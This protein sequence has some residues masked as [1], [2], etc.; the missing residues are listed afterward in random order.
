M[1]KLT[2]K[3]ILLAACLAFTARGAN[4]QTETQHY[5]SVIKDH[6]F[7][8]YKGMF[9]PAKGYLKHPFIT[10]GCSSYQDQL[11]DWD[12]WLTDVAL[13][14][15]LLE[16]GSAKDKQQ[17]FK[18]EQGCIL[19]FL[20]SVNNGY[21]PVVISPNN[22]NI[23]DTDGTNFIQWEHNMH[24]PCLAQHAAFLV[25][26]NGGNAEWLRDE[27]PKLQAFVNCYYNHYRNKATGLYFWETDECIGVDNDPSTFF[28]PYG[29][30]GSILLNCFMYKELEAMVYLAGRLNETEIGNSYQKEA[31][32][33]LQAIRKNCWDPKDG[34]YYS[35]DLNLRP[36]TQP[37]DKA[38][39][40]HMN[41]PRNWDCLIQR[42]GVWSGF[43]AMWSGFAT[44]EQAKE[45]V[46]KNLLDTNTFDAPYGICSLSKMEKM[47]DVRATSNPSNWLGPIWINANYF[48]FRGLVKY[49][50]NDEARKLVE[51]T[52]K[53]IGMDYEKSGTLHEY[54]LPEN[55]EPV[56][57]RGFQDWNY[58]VLNM[59]AWYQ[60]KP[61]VEEF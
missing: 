60:G 3:I 13:R 22:K 19:D 20:D 41:Q 49:G 52:I 48:V 24:K 16:N 10:P 35:V 26:L 4:T 18:Y 11:W 29:S 54:Y 5:I 53:L 45:M 37:R 23:M 1:N 27:F 17:A 12:S 28:R 15:I 7:K 2:N 33:L 30:S 31:D 9:K 39:Q 32:E 47:Y 21:I 61:C 59:I 43:L 40:F 56:M 42:L 14:Q 34:F 55:G 51:K 57:N 25:K 8:D 44:P 38:W 6:I 58:L 46:E 50:Y 36:V